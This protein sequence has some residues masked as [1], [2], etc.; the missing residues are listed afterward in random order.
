VIHGEGLPRYHSSDFG[1]LFVEYNIVLPE[2]VSDAAAK[3]LKE[4]FGV[5]AKEA[6]HNEL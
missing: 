1:D 2:K 6:S 5:I 3:K 4:A